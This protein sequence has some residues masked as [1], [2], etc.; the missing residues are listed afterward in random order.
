M[1]AD[2]TLGLNLHR[3]VEMLLRRIRRKLLMQR[4]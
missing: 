1:E 3:G 2:E 4:W